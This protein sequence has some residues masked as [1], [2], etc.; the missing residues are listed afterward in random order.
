M[1]VVGT[2]VVTKKISYRTFKKQKISF[3]SQIIRFKMFFFLLLICEDLPI[4][5]TPHVF[6]HPFVKS[7]SLPQSSFLCSQVC[8]LMMSLHSKWQ[9]EFMN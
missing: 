7:L 1:V 5:Q 2:D 4:P 9:Q 6:L 8:V 3:E